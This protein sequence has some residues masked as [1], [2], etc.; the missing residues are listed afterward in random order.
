MKSKLAKQVRKLFSEGI[1]KRIPQFRELSMTEIKGDIPSGDRLYLWP[2]SEDLY[3]YLL[4]CI[5]SQKMGDAFTIEC[6]YTNKKR[7]PASVPIMYPISAFKS[8]P[9]ISLPRDGNMRFRIG[10]LF[11][12]HKDY[13]WWIAP[14]SQYEDLS[15]RQILG[16][17]G[18]GVPNEIIAEAIADALNKIESYVSPYFMNIIRDYDSNPNY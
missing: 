18:N 1:R 3:F 16:H 5:A 2:H 7:F 4:L 6:A 15:Q 13:W 14:P 8:D 11:D 12:D 10:E 9:A 17:N